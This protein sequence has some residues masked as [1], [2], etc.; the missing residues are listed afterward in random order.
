MIP[1]RTLFSTCE[2]E[3]ASFS[4]KKKKGRLN[5]TTDKVSC[6]SHSET[7]FGNIY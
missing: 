1:M 4:L 5:K 7:L 2:W 3:L 6:C